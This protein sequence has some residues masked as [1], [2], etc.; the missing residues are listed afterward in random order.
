V[1]A[2]DEVCAR[3]LGVRSGDVESG[4]SIAGLDVDGIVDTL[5]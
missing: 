2:F 3:N 1:V 5:V 4:R